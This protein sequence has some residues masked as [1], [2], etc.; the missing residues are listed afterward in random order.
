MFCN[1]LFLH[2]VL[3]LSL[4]FIFFFFYFL[5]SLKA[6]V[7]RRQTEKNETCVW[8]E[9]LFGEMS[10]P[11]L[12]PKQSRGSTPCGQKAAM[13]GCGSLLMPWEG[14]VGVVGGPQTGQQ[15]VM[16]MDPAVQ[17]FVLPCRYSVLV[18]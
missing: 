4:L 6:I 12:T 2:L 3:L 7:S 11:D 1:N 13:G 16:R 17:R 8:P 9:W 5:S 15:T 18:Q 10:R 14:K